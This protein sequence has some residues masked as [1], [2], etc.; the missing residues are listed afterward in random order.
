MAEIIAIIIFI[1]SLCGI[2]VILFRKIPAMK[3]L[4]IEKEIARQE[5]FSDIGE[6]IKQ[7]NPF[8]FTCFEKFLKKFLLRVRIFSLKIENTVNSLLKKIREK[9]E[10]KNDFSDD[11]GEDNNKQEYIEKDDIEHIKNELKDKI[12]MESELAP[13][14]EQEQEQ[15]LKTEKDNYWEELKK[16]K[17][18]KI[19][20]R[21]IAKT[22]K[23][24]E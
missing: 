18:K 4:P 23:K 10:S 5:S 20:P 3:E 9:Q 22:R 14:I 11:G 7:V 6:K 1:G 13:E 15:E 2:G 17:K 21:K 12:E 24:L 16:F 19:K 8:G